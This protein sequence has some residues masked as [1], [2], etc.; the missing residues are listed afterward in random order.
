MNRTTIPHLLAF[1]NRLRII[2][3]LSTWMVLLVSGLEIFRENEVPQLC[4]VRV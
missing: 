4:G 2:T 1:W 3:E